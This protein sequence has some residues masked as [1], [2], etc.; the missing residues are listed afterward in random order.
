M[1]PATVVEVQ[2]QSGRLQELVVAMPTGPTIRR[3]EPHFAIPQVQHRRVR[4]VSI[5]VPVDEA[6]DARLSNKVAHAH[7]SVQHDRHTEQKTRLPDKVSCS[8]P[9]TGLGQN[10]C[11]NH[12]MSH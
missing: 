6:V 7:V 1:S 9:E 4:Q 3:L 11:G 10:G 2:K 12:P 5:L 8:I